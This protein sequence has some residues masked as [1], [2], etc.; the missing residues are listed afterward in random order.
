MLNWFSNLNY[1]YQALI[2]TLFTY[3]I[4]A[5][6]ASIVFF[7]KKVSKNVMEATTVPC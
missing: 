7:F 6:G 1:V 4:T 3:S 5:L 2:A